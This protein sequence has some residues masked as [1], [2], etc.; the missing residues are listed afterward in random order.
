V[1]VSVEQMHES[2]A[3]AEKTYDDEIGAFSTDGTFDPEAVAVLKQSFL[4]MGMLKD[5]PADDQM[6]TS[7]FLPVKP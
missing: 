4:D 5:K 6:Y 7:Q 1:K 2:K 3:V